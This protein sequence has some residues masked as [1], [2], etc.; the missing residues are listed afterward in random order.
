MRRRNFLHLG[1]TTNGP[2][3]LTPKARDSW[4]KSNQ[5]HNITSNYFLS[6]T[7]SLKTVQT[8]VHFRKNHPFTHLIQ[9][10]SYPNRFTG[11]WSPPVEVDIPHPE[12]GQ[13][14]V[15]LKKFNPP[16]E[17]LNNFCSAIIQ[18]VLTTP[19]AVLFESTIRHDCREPSGLQGGQKVPTFLPS[20]TCIDP[21]L[22]SGLIQ[23]PQTPHTPDTTCLDSS[24]KAGISELCK[25]KPLATK[26][27]SSP[28]PLL[29]WTL[30]D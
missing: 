11:S 17:L 14:D 6:K 2:W 5:L 20:R 7:L 10:K 4:L 21:E 13:A 29:W 19:V 3:T 15:V 16:Q 30:N 18:S 28:E 8:T 24:S 25:P 1:V 22:G 12:E 27:A 26:T 9:Q 23:S